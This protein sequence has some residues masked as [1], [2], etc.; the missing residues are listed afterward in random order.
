[1]V[2]DHGNL[3]LEATDLELAAHRQVAVQA[4][5]IELTGLAGNM[6]FHRITTTAQEFD[7]RVGAITMIA[8]TVQSTVGRL[9][10]KARNSF[11]WIEN[12][13]ETR[14]GRMRLQIE[15]RFHLKSKHAT[16]LAEGQVK[17]DGEKIDLG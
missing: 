12:L 9:I 10:L 14:A 11:S 16:I 4:P 7:A 15:N 2:T 6:K 3:R 8:Q 13:N 1:M 5:Q 17:I